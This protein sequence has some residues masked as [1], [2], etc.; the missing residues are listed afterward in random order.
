MLPGIGTGEYVIIA[1]LA[2]IVI[3][4]KDLPMLMRKLGAFINRLRGMANEFRASFDE[5][6]RQ[7]ELDELRKQVEELRTGQLM[8]PLSAEIAPAMTEIEQD[9]RAGVSDDWTGRPAGAPLVEE[10]TPARKPRK[11][12]AAAAK[13]A[14]AKPASTKAKPAATKATPAKARAAKPAPAKATPAKPAAKKA[15][16]RGARS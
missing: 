1:L 8:Q 5:M 3:G 2:L 4:P 10:A 16:A 13:P 7:S 11:S 12:R 9:I 6:A 15:P 14:P